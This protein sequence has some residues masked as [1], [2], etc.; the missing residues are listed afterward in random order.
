[1]GIFD[2][3]YLPLLQ[4]HTSTLHDAKQSSTSSLIAR[5]A[6][7]AQM[8]LHEAVFRLYQKKRFDHA[9]HNQL[10]LM[11]A[12][13]SSGD[14]IESH[15]AK[16]QKISARDGFSVAMIPSMSLRYFQNCHQLE[17]YLTIGMGTNTTERLSPHD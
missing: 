10:D 1:M 11:E 16:P 8:S 15:V 5:A 13:T 17:T 6:S 9:V 3:S 14:R 4:P 2:K 12:Y 7:L